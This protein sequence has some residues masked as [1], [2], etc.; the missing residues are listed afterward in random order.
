VE[1]NLLWAHAPTANRLKLQAKRD[2]YGRWGLAKM[3]KRRDFQGEPV[4]A[5][6]GGLASTAE[7]CKNPGKNAIRYGS[8]PLKWVAFWVQT[9]RNEAHACGKGARKC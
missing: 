6:N 9:M 1:V 2:R 5:K 7:K 8:D 4:R 3:Q